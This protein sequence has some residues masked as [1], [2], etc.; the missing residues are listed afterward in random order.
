MSVHISLSILLGSIYYEWE[1]LFAFVIERLIYLCKTGQALIFN[2]I[3][4]TISHLL[5]VWYFSIY[6]IYISLNIHMRNR[7]YPTGNTGGCTL[8]STLIYIPWCPSTNKIRSNDVLELSFELHIQKV[9]W[10]PDQNT[11]I[12]F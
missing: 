9:F 4:E 6:D 2:N 11:I 1:L 8:L 7:L 5:W 3:E 10:A 12:I